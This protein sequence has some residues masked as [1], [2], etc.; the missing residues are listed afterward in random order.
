MARVDVLGSSTA[1]LGR[2][3]TRQIAPPKVRE[4]GCAV[5]VVRVTLLPLVNSEDRVPGRH[6][7]RRR[8]IAGR[9]SAQFGGPQLA[10]PWSPPD[11]HKALKA[12]IAVLLSAAWQRALCPLQLSKNLQR[13]GN[14]P[15]AWCMRMISSNP[16]MKFVRVVDRW[17]AAWTMPPTC[18]LTQRTCRPFAPLSRER[19]APRNLPAH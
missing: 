2:C 6:H 9:R 12:A 16:T 11:D 5:N 7:H 3:S 18:W 10:V 19:P 4:G 1:P 14:R 17:A 15:R 8:G 13:P